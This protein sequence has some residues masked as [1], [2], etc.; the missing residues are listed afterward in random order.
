MTQEIVLWSQRAIYN[1]NND[2][3]KIYSKPA[4]FAFLEI[5]TVDTYLVC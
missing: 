5:M 1:V 3:G 2:V 4:Q